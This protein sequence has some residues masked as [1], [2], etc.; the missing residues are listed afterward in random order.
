MG[1]LQNTSY[2]TDNSPK[3]NQIYL[4]I[5]HQLAIELVKQA[6]YT[7]TSQEKSLKLLDRVEMLGT[8]L[9]ID[10]MLNI[11]LHLSQR[12]YTGFYSIIFN[13]A[14]RDL[15]NTEFWLM[16]NYF[17][18]LYDNNNLT[19]L[20]KSELEKLHFREFNALY[21]AFKLASQSTCVLTDLKFFRESEDVN[22]PDNQTD[23]LYSQCY[24]QICIAEN[25]KTTQSLQSAS[26]STFSSPMNTQI[27]VDFIPYSK[28]PRI[29]CLPTKDLLIN[30]IKNEINLS[31][32]DNISDTT[33]KRIKQK[34][35]IEL[36]LIKYALEKDFTGK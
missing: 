10:E 11:A 26:K 15:N 32:N 8:I 7:D 4:D 30:T 25:F 23:D 17:P 21:N 27:I 14:A 6:Y 18:E 29:Y 1:N 35:C 2:I 34:F 12:T 19:S 22:T 33:I 9:S 31:R 13:K 5:E 36:K 24:N 3:S 20:E 16:Q 28:I